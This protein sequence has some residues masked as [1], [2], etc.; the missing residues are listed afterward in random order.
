MEWVTTSRSRVIM[1]IGNNFER[2]SISR[3]PNGVIHSKNLLAA[4]TCGCKAFG[5]IWFVNFRDIRALMRCCCLRRPLCV[6]VTAGDSQCEVHSNVSFERKV[7][8]IMNK[9]DKQTILERGRE[10][11][12]VEVLGYQVCPETG[13]QPCLDEMEQSKERERH[14]RQRASRRYIEGNRFNAC[15]ATSPC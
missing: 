1:C 3:I 9:G 5:R 10:K 6:V 12:Q 8:D 13:G 14:L 2:K 4:A 15:F 7:T 11:V